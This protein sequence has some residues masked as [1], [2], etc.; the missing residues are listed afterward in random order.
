MKNARN[1]NNNNKIKCVLEKEY[2]KKK[3]RMWKGG[4]GVNKRR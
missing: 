2:G 4:K 1:T 3:T